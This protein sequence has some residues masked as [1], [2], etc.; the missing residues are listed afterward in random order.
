MMASGKSA[1]VSILRIV[2]VKYVL[3]STSSRREDCVL[4]KKIPGEEMTYS[5]RNEI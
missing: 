1:F 5:E 3:S 2:E 4:A